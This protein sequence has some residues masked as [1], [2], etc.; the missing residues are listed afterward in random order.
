MAPD[1]LVASRLNKSDGGKNMKLM[2]NTQCMQSVS[3]LDPLTSEIRTTME[4]GLQF[5][6]NGA[7]QQKGLK[8]ILTERGLWDRNY[9]L[10]DVIPTI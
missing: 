7:G 10:Q 9:N 2:R 3:Q 6:Q 5:M 1:A 8:T 4:M